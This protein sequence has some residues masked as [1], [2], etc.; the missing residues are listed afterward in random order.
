MKKGSGFQILAFLTLFQPLA[1]TSRL[2]N[3]IVCHAFTVK[4][5]PEQVATDQPPSEFRKIA[6]IENPNPATQV[7]MVLDQYFGFC[8]FGLDYIFV[9][10]RREWQV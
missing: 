9:A 3:G 8:Y 10:Y 6:S 7:T 2:A 4:I 1:C 5:T